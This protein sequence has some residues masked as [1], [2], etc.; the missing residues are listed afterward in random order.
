MSPKDLTLPARTGCTILAVDKGGARY[1]AGAT[2]C[3]CFLSS[4]SRA[5]PFTV[6]S[7]FKAATA[8]ERFFLSRKFRCVAPPASLIK[9]VPAVETKPSK[10]TVRLR[11]PVQL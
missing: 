2:A 3:H 10:D 8:R 5:T 6:W 11:W 1:R 7:G 4:A 9:P